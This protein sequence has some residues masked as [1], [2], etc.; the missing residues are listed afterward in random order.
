MFLRVLSVLGAAAAVAV[1]GLAALRL[2][3][4]RNDARVWAELRARGGGDLRFDPAVLSGLPEPAARYLRFAITPGTPLRTVVEIDMSGDFGL[5]TASAPGYRPMQA[6]QVLAA[7]HGFVWVMR[8]GIVGGSD[9]LGASGSWTRFRLGGLVP[10]ARAGW[11]D[12]H[13][14]SAFARTVAEGVFWA[15]A[16]VLPGAGVVWEAAGP[17]RARVTV[18]ADGLTQTVELTL[19]ADGAPLSM[20]MPRWSNANPQARWQIQPFGATFGDWRD[21]GGYRLP[22]RVEAGNFYGT[23]DWF[24]FYRVAV[25]SI[26]FPG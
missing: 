11:S 7:P 3:D 9:G 24:P 14:R 25:T 13:R 4:G 5:G 6:R 12:D 2:A 19:R 23:P 17:D 22:A 18:S 26:R 16:S 21:F 1:G 20:V 10:V 8:A 15:P